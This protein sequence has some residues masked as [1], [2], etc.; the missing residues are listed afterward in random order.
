VSVEVA[1]I[2]APKGQWQIFE[3]LIGTL[4]ISVLV[5]MCG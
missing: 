5:C 3:A 4:T 2:D 1:E